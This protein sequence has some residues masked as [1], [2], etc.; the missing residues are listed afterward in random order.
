M[1]YRG[2]KR[3]ET[4]LE[5]RVIPAWVSRPLMLLG[6]FLSFVVVVDGDWS[7]VVIG[8][9]MALA[10]GWLSRRQLEVKLLD[11]SDPDVWI[12]QTTRKRRGGR[13]SASVASEPPAVE[14]GETAES[15]K[16]DLAASYDH[17]FAAAS[18]NP[19]SA[20]EPKD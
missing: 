13:H 18:K 7:A 11:H 1:L 3:L 15:V 16:G 2:W 20:G 4:W 17:S 8:L 5:K 14:A 6:C 10:V 19:F 12:V 9:V